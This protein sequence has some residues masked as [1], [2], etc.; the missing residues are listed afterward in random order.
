MDV[1]EK[2][3]SRINFESSNW[4]GV[5]LG[6]LQCRHEKG[7]GPTNDASKSASHKV[8]PTVKL[9]LGFRE[10]FFKGRHLDPL[11]LREMC[12]LTVSLPGRP[13]LE[14]LSYRIH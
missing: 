12:L 8:F 14:A 6:A 13:K 5:C 3:R 4:Y 10:G 11:L 9:N 7:A 1:S 2:Y